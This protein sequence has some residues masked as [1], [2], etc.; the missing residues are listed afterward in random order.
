MLD[1]TQLSQSLVFELSQSDMMNGGLGAYLNRLSE[2]RF[3]FFMD[4][5]LT[6]D[7]DY[8][9]LAKRGFNFLKVD[10]RLLLSIKNETN[11]NSQSEKIREALRFPDIHPIAKRFELES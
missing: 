1:N 8:L 3:R 11:A 10:S 9:E 5:L 4:Y 7:C 2:G 6:P